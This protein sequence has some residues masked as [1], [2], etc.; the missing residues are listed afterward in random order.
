MALSDLDRYRS[1]PLA[2]ETVD[3][4]ARDYRVYGSQ[5]AIFNDA[6]TLSDKSIAQF[7]D[8]AEA[9]GHIKDSLLRADTLGTM[10]S[11][12]GLWQI[13]S[14]AGSLPA[15]K[16]DE[17]FAALVTP[18]TAAVHDDRTL[19]DAYWR[20]WREAAAL[21]DRLEIGW[22]AASAHRGSVGGRSRPHRRGI[23]HPA[24]AGRWCAFWRLS[25]LYR[26]P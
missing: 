10:Q 7:M 20:D 15:A 19:F 24:G 6:A 12:V 21:R 5:Y 25:G 4:L 22:A 13:F 14:R 18:S 17:T 11:L 26:S 3:L 16:A 2:P 23:S 1:K 9:T 8:T